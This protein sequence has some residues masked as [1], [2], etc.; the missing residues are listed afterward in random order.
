MNS[1]NFFCDLLYRM[2]SKN[3]NKGGQILAAIG[4]KGSVLYFLVGVFM[5]LKPSS[6]FVSVCM[7]YIEIVRLVRPTSVFVQ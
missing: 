3:V 6:H 7:F 2:S 5:L 1:L 4:T